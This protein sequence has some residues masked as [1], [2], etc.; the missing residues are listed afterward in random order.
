MRKTFKL[1]SI[2]DRLPL[3][4]VQGMDGR[5]FNPPLSS[6]QGFPDQARVVSWYY[7]EFVAILYIS[8]G[9]GYL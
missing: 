1:D 6:F 8:I 5:D 4:I 2:G 7:Y 9:K 3:E